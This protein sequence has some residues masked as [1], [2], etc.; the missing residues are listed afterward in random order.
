MIDGVMGALLRRPGDD[1]VA[2]SWLHIL[3][4][5]GGGRAGPALAARMSPPPFLPTAMDGDAGPRSMG[6]TH[7]SS[8][9]DAA[10]LPRLPWVD[11]LAQRAAATK[12]S[13]ASMLLTSAGEDRKV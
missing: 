5:V 2:R 9:V 1:D 13:A 11:A 7:V 10:R 4:N 8:F 3:S 12:S 6:T